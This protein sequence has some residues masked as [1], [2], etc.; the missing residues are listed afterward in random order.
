MR[1]SIILLLI[2]LNIG[3]KQTTV[4]N[5]ELKE[6][7]LKNDSKINLTESNDLSKDKFLKSQVDDYMKAI[8]GRNLDLVY[9]YCYPDIILWAEDKYPDM[10]KNK[11]DFKKVF[12]EPMKKLSELEKDKETSVEYEI[13]EITKRLHS[14]DGI[15]MIYLIVS[16]ITIK[17]KLEERKNGDE[18]VAI[19]FDGGEN[20]KFMIKDIEMTKEILS[21]KFSE[22]SINKLLN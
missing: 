3:C 21:Y 2:I 13:G 10:V 4:S 17:H 22:K 14:D 6:E 11:E 20:W 1:K 9:D 12:L 19:S 15:A 16:S 18:Y 7:V 8:L 5:V